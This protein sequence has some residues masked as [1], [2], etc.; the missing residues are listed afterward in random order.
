MQ[1]LFVFH[2]N[3]ECVVRKHTF[4]LLTSYLLFT[5]LFATNMLIGWLFAEKSIICRLHILL[6]NIRIIETGNEKTE[7][8]PANLLFE[9]RRKTGTNE[10]LP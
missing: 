4:T 3:A 9:L 10:Q 2:L 6:E 1:Y 7:D 8:V 5:E